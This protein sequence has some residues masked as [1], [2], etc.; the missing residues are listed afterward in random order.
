M[1]NEKG[2]LRSVLGPA[3]MAMA[4][5]GLI[6]WLTSGEPAAP[7]TQPEPAA[8]APGPSVAEPAPQPDPDQEPAVPAATGT[9]A[10]AA[11]PAPGAAP[12]DAHEAT[13]AEGGTSRAELI[14]HGRLM[15][16]AALMNAIEQNNVEHARAMRDQLQAKRSEGY[17]TENDFEALDLV[18]D[19]LEHVS[20]ARDEARDFLQFGSP[21]LLNEPLK[22][23]CLESR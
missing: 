1:A 18:V 7:P 8:P 9:T 4:G 5:V 12:G 20:D 6:A 22:R 14:R 10:Q 11:E 16:P 17:L 15:I 19:C 21:S 23:A 13:D 2:V 3:L